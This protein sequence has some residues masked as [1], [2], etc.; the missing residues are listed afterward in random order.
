MTNLLHEK[1]A[2]PKAEVLKMLQTM[3]KK[4]MQR[5]DPHNKQLYQFENKFLN[6]RDFE[7]IFDSYDVL[8]IQ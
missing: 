7:S 3:Q 5:I 6:Q 2:D 4:N 8:N 1:P